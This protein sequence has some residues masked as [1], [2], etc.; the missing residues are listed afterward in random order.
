MGNTTPEF[1][2]HIETI[3]EG[4]ERRRTLPEVQQE[5]AEAAINRLAIQSAVDSAS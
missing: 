4:N 1:D 2:R 3:K 5:L